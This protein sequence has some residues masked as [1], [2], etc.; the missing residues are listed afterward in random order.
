VT[1]R[2]PVPY[3]L[4][5]ELT[6]RCPLRCAYCSNPVPLSTDHPQLSTAEWARV[7]QEAEELGVLQVHFSGGEPLLRNDLGALVGYARA[8]ELYTSLVTSGIPLSRDRLARLCDAGLESVQ[9]SMQGHERDFGRR[10]AGVDFHDAKLRAARWIKQLG[11]PLTLNIVLH[12][13]NIDAIEDII[14]MA[15][16]LGTDRLELANTQYL[17]WALLNRA[18]LLPTRVQLDMARH[19][20]HLA[21]ERL[22]GRMEVVFVLPEVVFVLPDYY[23]D[24]P[25]ACMEGWGRRFVVITPDGRVAPCQMAVTLPGLTFPRVGAESLHSIWNESPVFQLYR[26]DEWMPEPCRS[27]DGRDIDFGGCRCQA[28][29][30][31]GDAARADPACALSPDHAVVLEARR[32]ALT[33]E[34]LYPIRHR[35]LRHA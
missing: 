15:E 25:R 4:V 11:L 34:R 2:S 17:G 23:S 12:R 19:A 22:R 20:A 16:D 30:L 27:C 3:T 28:F 14:V 6:Y 1:E 13:D 8:H 32:A 18:A 29:H 5:A 21:R 35:A 9:L 26:G 31:T 10:I 24:V 7:L 33:P